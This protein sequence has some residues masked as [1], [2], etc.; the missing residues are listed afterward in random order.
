MYVQVWPG[1][2]PALLP[3]ALGAL[4]AS[5]A[6]AV[7]VA[8][9]ARV[10]TPTLGVH[11]EV[12]KPLALRKPGDGVEKLGVVNLRQWTTTIKRTQ[13]PVMNE[14]RSVQEVFTHRC[15]RSMVQTVCT[16]ATCRGSSARRGRHWYGRIHY[17]RSQHVLSNAICL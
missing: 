15:F 3:G 14:P 12:G 11:D 7:A 16:N 13:C 4:A 8:T 5:A 17:N 10:A 2:P 9:T 1:L 6:L